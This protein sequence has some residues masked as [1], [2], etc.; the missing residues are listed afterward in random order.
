MSDEISTIAHKL[1]DLLDP[2]ALFLLVQTGDGIRLVARS[3]TDHVDVSKIAEHFGGGGH[4]RAAAALIRLNNAQ[5]ESGD[6][7]NAHPGRDPRET[8]AYFA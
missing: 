1:R 7:Q 2:D 6:N 8:A 5:N 4:G 3:L